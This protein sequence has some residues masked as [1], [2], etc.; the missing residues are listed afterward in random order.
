MNGAHEIILLVG[1]LMLLAVFA[2]FASTRI[3]APLQLALIGVGMLA[4]EDG[5]GG[6][7]FSDFQTAY[8]IGS[9]ALAVIL[10]QGGLNTE[11]DMIRRALWPAVALATVGVAI[12]AGIVG[13]AVV[14]LFG[15]SWPAALL[16]GATT[17][18]TDAAAVSVLLRTSGLRLPAHVTAALELESGLN[19]PM[20][21]FLTLTL[22]E[23][24]G[25]GA[26][27]LFGDAA[28]MFVREMAG[29]AVI[30][31]AAGYAM[32]RVFRSVGLVKSAFPVVAL[33]AALAVFGGAQLLGTSGFLATY[34]AGIVVGNYDHPAGK[35][36]GQFFDTLGWVAQNTLFLMLGLLVTPHQLLPI[37]A[38]ALLVT[39]V[40]VI[41][42]RPVSS[43]ACLLPLRWS[44]REAGFV[45]WAGLRGGVPIYLAAIALLQGVRS[46]QT[47]FNVVFVAVI[48]S[49]AIQGWT[50]KPAARL[51]RVEEGT[52]VRAATTA[53]R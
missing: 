3:G 35:P 45:A 8:L 16:L 24:A 5:P 23:A 17:A 50:I 2:G 48:V 28:W 29:G 22:V 49:V 36:V 53:A 51:L 19:D 11:R 30:G 46:G 39:A 18:P 1:V 43:M 13:A 40:L 38:P 14:A 7:A 41:L 6:I 21:V 27:P 9:L 37:L 10:F 26:A 4:G 20:S 25:P 44:V 12:S 32:L 31:L 33:A 47:L 52:V 34:L 15:I 42:A